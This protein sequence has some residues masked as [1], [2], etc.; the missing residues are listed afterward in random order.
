MQWAVDEFRFREVVDHRRTVFFAVAPSRYPANQVVSVRRRERQ[1]FHELDGSFARQFHQHEVRLHRLRLLLTGLVHTH[2]RSDRPQVLAVVE[3]LWIGHV[4]KAV[5]SRLQLKQQFRIAH[6]FA[7]RWRHGRC[8][9][10][11]SGKNPAILHDDRI[12]RVIHIKRCS[13][14][15]GVDDHLNA[16]PHVVNEVV[17]ECIVPGVGIAVGGRKRV[18]NPRQPTIVA[19]DDVRIRFVSEEWRERRHAIAHVATHEQPA[20]WVNIVTKREL[21]QVTSVGRDEESAKETSEQDATV[22]L[23][24]RQT[25]GLA[26]RVVKFLLPRLHVHVGVG[27]LPEINLRAL[28]NHA[29]Y[30]ALDGHVTQNQCRQSFRS[31]PIHRVHG[32]TVAVRVNKFLVDPIAAAFWELLDV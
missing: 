2:F 16:I 25:V 14:I 18:H 22:A 21:R 5:H 6:V 12:L 8:I 31:E 32:D 19:D 29:L 28:Y 15:V 1:N 20:L 7:E 23:V 17:A 24:G 10:E 13:A 3:N 9:L 4:I 27:E 26:L 30:G 11:Q